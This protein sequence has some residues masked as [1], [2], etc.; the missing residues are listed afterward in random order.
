M[1]AFIFFSPLT[2]ESKWESFFNSFK[3]SLLEFIAN[4]TLFSLLLVKTFCV[5]SKLIFITYKGSPGKVSFEILIAK[6]EL[7]KIKALLLLKR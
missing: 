2:E 6:T 7:P 4:P 1:A 5:F 3:R